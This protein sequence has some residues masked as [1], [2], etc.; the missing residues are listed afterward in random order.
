M[1][2]TEFFEQY[3]KITDLLEDLDVS[4]KPIDRITSAVDKYWA[5]IK[6]LSSTGRAYVADERTRKDKAKKYWICS[7]NDDGSIGWRVLKKEVKRGNP[8]EWKRIGD[9]GGDLY[10]PESEAKT[11]VERLKQHLEFYKTVK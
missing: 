11:F 8:S 3:G 10:F 7:C 6:A 1:E 2:D 5:I 9:V 4:S